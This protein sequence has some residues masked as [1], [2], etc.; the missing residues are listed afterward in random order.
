[1]LAYFSC[2]QTYQLW[3][4]TDYVLHLVQEDIKLF[5]SPR[6]AFNVVGDPAYIDHKA[7]YTLDDVSTHHR[8]QAHIEHTQSQTTEAPVYSTYSACLHGKPPSTMGTQKLQTDQRWPKVRCEPTTLKVQKFNNS[9]SIII[10]YTILPV[11]LCIVYS[12]TWSNIIKIWTISTA[13]ILVSSK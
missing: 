6:S 8:A 3:E 4:L 13:V 9:S 5:M 2:F 7:G 10:Q 12:I 11:L 1:M